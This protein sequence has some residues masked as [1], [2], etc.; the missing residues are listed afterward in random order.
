MKQTGIKRLEKIAK[1]IRLDT[2]KMLYEAET[3]HL[4]GA[5]SSLELLTALYFYPILK[6]NPKKPDWENR[7]YFLLS[8][9]H[10]CP[11]FY[12]VLAHA[13]FFPLSKLKNNLFK[14]D[15]GLEGHPIKGSLSGIEISS[16]SLGMGLSVGLG[17]ALGL[18]MKKRDNK[19]VVMMSDGE[20]QE[21][22]T[23][24]AVMAVN[25]YQVANLIAIIDRNGIQIAGNTEKNIKL[26][27]LDKKY[28]SFGWEV[29][30][31]DGHDFNQIIS[32][33]EKAMQ[34]KKPTVIIAKTIPAKGVYSLEG[35]E[36]THHP[37][38][39]EEIYKKTL[40]SYS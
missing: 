37:L 30:K 14:L 13:G 22:S 12:A 28:Q 21:G 11:S 34:N 15:T 25:H 31:I 35:R 10:V 9:G 27:P 1:K 18:R 3:G 4:G 24:E 40:N 2:L 23:W 32:A 19:V 7:D 6:F 26:E 8:H 29:I 38:L 39:T 17:I 16:G 5:M 36:D 20:Q 33:F